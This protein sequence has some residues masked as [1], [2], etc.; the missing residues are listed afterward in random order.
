MV[1]VPANHGADYRRVIS[2][3]WYIYLI[4]EITLRFN[5]INELI[6][7]LIICSPPFWGRFGPWFE[8]PKNYQ[9][10]LPQCWY[11]C[12]LRSH[13]LE[14]AGPVSSSA[15]PR[16]RMTSLTV[17]VWRNTQWPGQLRSS[18]GVVTRQGLVSVIGLATAVVYH[19]TRNPN[20][21]SK[22]KNELKGEFYCW[23]W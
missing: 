4:N 5:E 22:L 7:E 12:A 3:N 20:P 16:G 9:R 1:D 10:T 17:F 23:K 19:V 2:L 13:S 8:S 11:L 14:N 21:N 18:G 15:W 6:N